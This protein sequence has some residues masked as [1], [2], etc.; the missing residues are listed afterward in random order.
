[1]KTKY[2]ACALSAILLLSFALT[3]CAHVSSERAASSLASS[4]LYQPPILRLEKHQVIATKDGL[5][6]PQVDE[7]WHSDARFR[8]LENENIDLAAA[9][10]AERK[11]QK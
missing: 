2:S 9:L 7:I 1:M 5:H 4:T 10:A 11:R 6:I 3:G 8:Q